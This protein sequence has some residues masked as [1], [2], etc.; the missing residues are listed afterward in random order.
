VEG[1]HPLLAV[2]RALP[3]EAA[4]AESGVVDQED[5]ALLVPDPRLHARDPGLGGEV[6]LEGLN[7]GAKVPCK[8]RAQAFEPVG[9]PR[10]QEQVVVRGQP[11]GENLADPA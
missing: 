3:E 7:R 4:G 8:L 11:A 2:E 9:A 5:Q 6:R 10:N 1:V